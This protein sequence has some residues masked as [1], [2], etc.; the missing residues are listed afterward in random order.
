M[1][2]ISGGAIA[3][4]VNPQQTFQEILGFGGAF[5]DAMGV[6]LS[7][8]S[9]GVRENLMRSYFDTNGPS[10]ETQQRLPGLE[11]T[12]GRVPMASCDFS[13]HVYSYDDVA[14]DFDLKHF[15]LT[16]EDLKLKVKEQW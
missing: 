9:E 15:A 13:T 10:R 16:D 11:Y 2:Q 1:Q 14:D 3:L 7:Q 12:L 5:T 6:T 4:T 8:V